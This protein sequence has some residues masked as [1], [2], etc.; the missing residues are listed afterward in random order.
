MKKAL[1]LIAVVSVAACVHDD[2]YH[3]PYQN[4]EGWEH[5]DRGHVYHDEHDRDWHDNHNR[6]EYERRRQYEQHRRHDLERHENNNEYHRGDQ[7]DDRHS[8]AEGNIYIKPRDQTPNRHD[9][10]PNRREA[11]PQVERQPEPQAHPERGREQ[12][13]ERQHKQPTTEDQ[14]Q[15]VADDLGNIG[16]ILD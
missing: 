8:G 13:P 16:H 2:G 9:G 12:R 11:A 14:G 7:H 1:V 3:D 6:R 15:N 10:H 4:R 5:S